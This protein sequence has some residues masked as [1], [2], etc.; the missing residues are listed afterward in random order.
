MKRHLEANMQSKPAGNSGGRGEPINADNEEWVTR[1]ARR[2]KYICDMRSEWPDRIRGHSPNP[3]DRTLSKR[4]WEI[5]CQE[6]RAYYLKK[7]APVQAS[8]S[9]LHVQDA[10]EDECHLFQVCGTSMQ[11]AAWDC[12]FAGLLNLIAGKAVE[13]ARFFNRLQQCF[14][15]DAAGD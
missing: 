5:A 15:T 11:D 12:G 8:P 7:A 10:S 9:E 6:W 3:E 1:S 13:T 2:W 14:N 4:Q